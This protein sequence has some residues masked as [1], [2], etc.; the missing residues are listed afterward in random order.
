[1]RIHVVGGDVT[2]VAHF[3]A[4]RRHE[5]GGLGQGG[6]ALLVRAGEEGAGVTVEDV[7]VAGVGVDTQRAGVGLQHGLDLVKAVLVSSLGAK[8]LKEGRVFLAEGAVHLLVEL[9]DIKTGDTG[10][11]E[12]AH[13]RHQ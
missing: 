1:M 13:H 11:E 3:A 6:A 7:V 9:V 5:I 8:R 2:G 4:A 12:S 10:H